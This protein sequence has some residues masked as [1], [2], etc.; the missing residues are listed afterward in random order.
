VQILL[1][2]F[3]FYL[4]FT[5]GETVFTNFL[6]GSAILVEDTVLFQITPWLSI[7]YLCFVITKMVKVIYCWQNF[8]CD[9]E[10]GLQKPSAYLNNFT[11]L[12][13]NYFGIKRKVTLWFSNTIKVPVTFGFFTPV[14]LLP[15][16][17]INNITIQQ[18]ESLILHELAHIKA[19][20]FL[21][22]WFLLFTEN[23]FFFNPF[24]L[25]LCKQIRL[26]R[27]KSCDI[28]V[29]NFKYS[30]VLYAQTLV[31][32]ERYKQFIIPTLQLAA[33]GNKEQLLERVRFFSTYSCKGSNKN[34]SFLLK[35]TSTFF[36]LLI[37]LATLLPFGNK[38]IWQAN[39][40]KEMISSLLYNAL[41]EVNNPIFINN[42]IQGTNSIQIDVSKAVKEIEKQKPKIEDELKKIAPKLKNL[43]L[44]AEKAANALEDE[45]FVTPVSLEQDEASQ[46]IIIKEEQSGSKNATVK[47][48]SMRFING[49]WLLIPDWKAGARENPFDSSIPKDLSG[50]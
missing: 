24:I 11:N 29:L 9:N 43:Q 7:A 42:M 38:P 4:I 10:K 2:A 34:R 8:Y 21:L 20:D 50:Q 47:V 41:S 35:A 1:S 13:S 45:N 26:E 16:A 3:T 12:H 32:A 49:H 6:S 33:V 14:I 44:I 28:N 39:G 37:C 23:I 27:E 17:L 5:N 36:I 19:N 22:N 25:S 18:A 31:Q 30:P 46:K 40:G 48:Y 15:V